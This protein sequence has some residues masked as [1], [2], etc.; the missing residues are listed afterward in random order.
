MFNNILHLSP[1]FV[2]LLKKLLHR[3]KRAL[4]PVDKCFIISYGPPLRSEFNIAE[5]MSFTVTFCKNS[6]HMHV[7]VFSFYFWEIK[8]MF[9]KNET[10]FSPK[11]SAVYKIILMFCTCMSRCQKTILQHE[12]KHR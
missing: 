1:Y 7:N 11:F 9:S 3:H 12:F 6:Q 5:Q 8:Q 10:T 2:A 4:E